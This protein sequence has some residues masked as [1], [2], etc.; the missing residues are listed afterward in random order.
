[1]RAMWGNKSSSQE[2]SEI[3]R[4]IIPKTPPKLQKVRRRSPEYLREW[5]EIRRR[6]MP[7]TSIG[8]AKVQENKKTENLIEWAEKWHFRLMIFL[9]LFFH[10][11]LL[12]VVKDELIIKYKMC[13]ENV[14]LP[15]NPPLI[16]VLNGTK[17]INITRR[18]WKITYCV[19]V[20]R[21]I[22]PPNK[23]T[24]PGTFCNMPNGEVHLS[25]T[26]NHTTDD[27]FKFDNVTFRDV[28]NYEITWTTHLFNGGF[29]IYGFCPV[30]LEL[31]ERYSNTN[32]S[33]VTGL[34][35]GYTHS[36]YSYSSGRLLE[37]YIWYHIH[38][39]Y[40]VGVGNNDGVN[41]SE[42]QSLSKY[43]DGIL[44]VN[45]EEKRIT[46]YDL[47]NVSY[48]Y[49][50]C[51]DIR[52]F[53]IM[54]SPRNALRD[55]PDNTRCVLRQVSK[56]ESECQRFIAIVCTHSLSRYVIRYLSKYNQPWMLTY[57]TELRQLTSFESKNYSFAE[58]IIS[59]D[60]GTMA[61]TSNEKLAIR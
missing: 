10:T 12:I 54:C 38:S 23:V 5:E 21:K 11:I 17:N 43:N 45:D 16:Q 39:K 57:C 48:T 25:F 46:I 27:E 19:P 15:H 26:Y 34:S 32:G 4:R 40:N 53:L 49:L 8:L 44:F 22:Q 42:V 28:I 13:Q 51:Y 37:G 6:I 7:K 29:A 31:F 56:E 24:F 36:V 52:T 2:W 59:T 61:T 3:R 1:M 14:D 30:S 33:L 35:T 41:N 55:I 58:M 20:P 50:P 9:L 47:I 60:S 18:P